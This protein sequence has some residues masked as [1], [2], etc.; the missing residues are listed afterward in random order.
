MNGLTIPGRRHRL[1]PG[2][3]RDPRRA[4]RPRALVLVRRRAWTASSGIDHGQTQSRRGSYGRPLPVR[5]ASQYPVG[6]GSEAVVAG[7][8]TPTEVATGRR[9]AVCGW[10]S[11]RSSARSSRG[12]A[13]R[14]ARRGP[15]ASWRPRRRH[16][17]PDAAG[18]PGSV[19]ADPR[20]R[21]RG[22]RIAVFG[23]YDVDGVC[24]TAILLRALRALGADP[25]SGTCRAA[26]TTATASPG[27]AVERL[28]ARGAELLVTV[29]CGDHR[30]R[31][32][33]AP[34]ARRGST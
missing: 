26:S 23:D 13:S 2:A 14:D 9:L 16:D 25:S 7:G 3:D 12:V 11:R 30:R 17:P 6:C 32:G 1:R 34:P 33:R 8:A 4:D 21:R 15:R 5:L 27:R 24:S 18:R 20:P 29:D 10:A 19:R 31:G 22:S 28:A